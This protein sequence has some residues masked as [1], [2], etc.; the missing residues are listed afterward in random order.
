M[1]MT[2]Y[3]S[4]AKHVVTSRKLQYAMSDVKVN[5]TKAVA[6]ALQ[7]KSSILL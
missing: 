3:S 2:W 1:R 5:L 7:S 4:F 6:K